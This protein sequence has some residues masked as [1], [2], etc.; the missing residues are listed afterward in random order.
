[1]IIMIMSMIMSKINQVTINKQPKIDHHKSQK[2]PSIRGI[3]SCFS[4]NCKVCNHDDG[5]WVEHQRL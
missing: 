2:N 1:M 5:G 3:K 4:T